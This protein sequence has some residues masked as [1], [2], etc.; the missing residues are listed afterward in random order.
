MLLKFYFLFCK[1]IQELLNILLPPLLWSKESKN[2]WNRIY[3]KWFLSSNL[4]IL[5]F[6]KN[7]I[8]IYI[9]CFILNFLTPLKWI[10]SNN[11][12]GGIPFQYRCREQ[13]KLYSTSCHG[14]TDTVGIFNQITAFT[15]CQNNLVCIPR[16]SEAVFR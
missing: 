1:L 10:K 4:C 9:Y 12:I 16:D 14:A 2:K 7:N 8:S 15:F 6:I 5:R 13:E 11:L 3:K